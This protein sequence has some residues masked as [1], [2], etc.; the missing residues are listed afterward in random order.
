MQ[1]DDPRRFRHTVDDCLVHGGVSHKAVLADL[2]ALEISDHPAE[3]PETEPVT[4][5]SSD[6]PPE[7]QA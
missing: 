1:A 5:A 6:K 4:E 2:F 3:V 7:V